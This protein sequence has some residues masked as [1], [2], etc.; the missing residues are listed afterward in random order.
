M[1]RNFLKLLLGLVAFAIAF[2]AYSATSPKREHRSAWVTTAWR[3]CWPTTA[4][5]TTAAAA[6]QKAEADAILDVMQENGFNA[7]YFQVRGMSDAMYKSSYEPWSSYVSGTRGTA[8]TYDPLEYWVQAC[9][10]RGMECFAWV[11]PYRYES[12]VSGASWTGA[13]D[14][15]TTHPD[16]IME[17]NNA[18]ILNPGIAAVQTRIVDVCR[19]IVS[20]Y[21]VDGLV[22]DDYF[23]L[24]S[25]PMSYDSNLYKSSG[26]SLSQANWRRENVNSMVRKVYNMI[27]SVKPYVKFGISPAGVSKTSASKYGISTSLISKASDWQY[28]QIY[29]DPLA[30]LGEGT[31]DFIS[32]QLYWLTSHSTNGYAN[33]SKWWS[34]AC[35][36]VF[37]RHFYSSHSISFLDGANTTSNWSEIA[38][39]IQYNRDYTGNDAAGCVLFGSRDF[40]GVRNSGLAPYLKTNK[41][42]NIA[43]PPT[44]TWK[45]YAYN[46]GKVSNLTLSGSTLSWGGYNN[47]RYVV[48]AVPTGTTVSNDIPSQYIINV[49]YSTS[50]NVSGYTSGYKLGV[51][52]LDR[53]GYEYEVAW[54]GEDDDTGS[55][56]PG[57]E[58][59]TLSQVTINSPA[60]GSTVSKDFTFS[61]TALPES[62]VTYTIEVSTTSS[63]SNYYSKS[64][65]STT[66][67]SSNFNILTEGTT[68]YWRVKASKSGYS[69]SPYSWVGSFTIEKSSSGG[70]TSG[71]TTDPSSYSIVNGMKVTSK[72]FYAY[73]EDNFPSDVLTATNRGIAALNGKVYISQHGGKL[74]EFSGETG[75][76]LRTITLTGDCFKASDGTAHATYV[77]NDVF[78][79]DAG[80]LCVS[81]LTTNTSSDPI[82]VCTV[83]I[84]TGATTRIFESNHSS[85]VRIDHV[86]ACGNVTDKSGELWAAAA[87]STSVYRWRRTETGT[88]NEAITTIPSSAYYPTGYASNNSTAP[89]VMPITSGNNGFI[90]D[91]HNSAPAYLT[92]KN[93][94]NATLNDNFSNNSTIAP[95]ENNWNGMCA[96]N[97]GGDPIFIYANAIDPASFKVVTNPN[98]YDFA[99]M[100][101]LWTLPANGFGTALNGTSFVN[102]TATSKPV[103]VNNAD[104]SVTLYLYTPCTGLACY[105]LENT[106]KVS[107]LESVSLTSPTGGATASEGFNFYWS[108]ISGATYTLEVSKSSSFSDIAFSAVTTSSSYSSNN[109]SLETGTTYYWRIKAE[110]TGYNSSVS[111]VGSFVT[112]TPT[113]SKVELISPAYGETVSANGFKFEWSAVEGATYTFGFSTLQSFATI[114]YS[115][116]LTTNSI[117]SKDIDYEFIEGAT[118]YWHV[119]A[120]KNGHTESISDTGSFVYPIIT[121]DD[122]DDDETPPSAGADG[123]TYENKLGLSLECLWIQSL[124]AGNYPAEYLGRDQ[125]GMAA[126]KG[127]VYISERLNSVGYLL[128]F[129]GQTGEYLRTIELTGDYNRLSNGSSQGYC[130]NDVFTDGAGNLCV[131]NMVTS[132]SSSKQLTVCTVNIETGATTRM[133]ESDLETSGLR[134]DYCSAYG[135]ITKAGAKVYAAASSGGSAYQEYVFCWVKGNNGTWTIEN[136]KKANGY[137]PSTTSGFGRAP[138]VMPIDGERFIV[139]GES[140]YPSLYKFSQWSVPIQDSFDNNEEIKPSG[141]AN[142]G[143]CSASIKNIPLYIYSFNGGN[144]EFYN[145]AIVHNPNNYSFADMEMLWLIPTDGLGNTSHNYISAIPATCTND[146]G[147]L[148]LFIY[149]PNNGLAAYRISDAT[150]TKV[151]DINKDV[152]NAIKME[153]RIAKCTRTANVIKVYNTAGAM[154]A[155]E[156]NASQINLADIAE[157]V[158]IICTETDGAIAT[159]KVILE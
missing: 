103:A 149:V 23:Y 14:Y 130:C 94:R 20:N 112:E 84:E 49:P 142:A 13:N 30:W 114:M 75:E 131:S 1:K 73:S 105:L 51:S 4:G 108:A 50:V 140:C 82:S 128:E 139:D 88:W 99:D 9:H 106:N 87:S 93:G 52:V 17:Y 65:T 85:G 38:D 119:H 97:L 34:D 101:L 132:F 68:Y 153:G 127:N 40:T 118:Y 56:N 2:P 18:S 67:A 115:T 143:M 6:K 148:T 154:V 57:D 145:F 125:R 76:L 22:F 37:N 100:D 72:W 61:W 35:A 19:E 42:Q 110:K 21:D 69:D 3:M 33:L 27:Q 113:V 90:I 71:V 10:E 77:S 70:S 12:S 157:G 78:T 92:L 8:P 29:S 81:N 48:Y 59:G 120:S 64:T 86:S 126:Y 152:C 104:G 5:A 41:F 116:N 58:T 159:Q 31:V 98:N 134:I 43:L 158:Y 32:P 102:S 136:Q 133:F 62:N 95:L 55:D 60:D 111:A 146:D 44:I 117:S 107:D 91:G 150:M 79:D 63:F 155:T 144:N 138:R 109:F 122:D 66:Y 39:Q 129:D 135:D 80:N 141:M 25:V 16:W 89:R 28:D 26:S 36:D 54:L 45:S 124:V 121:P 47:M 24:N 83:N 7:V 46:P 123:F 151:E 11:N 96:A 15:R 53:Y 156:S 74:L 137:Y 147:S